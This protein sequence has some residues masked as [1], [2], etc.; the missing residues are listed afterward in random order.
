MIPAPNEVVPQRPRPLA[1][2]VEQVH[3]RLRAE[4]D[5][6]QAGGALVKNAFVKGIPRLALYQQRIY[7]VL[8]RDRALARRVRPLLPPALVRTVRSN[9]V[10]GRKLYQLVTP[11]T[12]P[13]DLDTAPPAS[14]H[15]LLQ[16]YKSAQNRF[17]IEWEVLAAIN[18]VETRFGR[19]LGPSSAGALGP[20]QFLPETW[21]RYG[22]G[23]ILDPH[24]AIPAAARYLVASG[25]DRDLRGALFAYNNSSN[26]VDAVLLYAR[27]MQ[28][29]VRAFYSYYFWQVFVA[30][31]KGDVQLTGPGAD[32]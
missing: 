24:D 12:P 1:R 28:R 32:V 22:R 11:I 5:D 10:A 21:E 16:A 26:Y 23:D 31:T 30:T 2:A 18:F 6:W 27:E 15:V 20:M 9:V 4:I 14:P 25:A 19:I 8:A 29:D 3:R 7:R 17:G 13:I